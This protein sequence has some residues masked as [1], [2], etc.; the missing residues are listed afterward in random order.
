MQCQVCKFQLYVLIRQ[1]Q[2]TVLCDPASLHCL[3][4]KQI[5]LA[6]SVEYVASKSRRFALEQRSQQVIGR[7]G[8]TG[9]GLAAM[10]APF[11]TFW[12]CWRII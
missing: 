12:Y 4:E 9:I 7:G 8:E 3:P 5:Q 2:N 10:T 11:K 1:R 6:M